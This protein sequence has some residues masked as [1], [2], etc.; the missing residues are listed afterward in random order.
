M[1]L[2]GLSTGDPSA[3]HPGVLPHPRVLQSLGTL[4]TLLPPSV[5]FLGTPI[6]EEQHPHPNPE[7]GGSGREWIWEDGEGLHGD[8]AR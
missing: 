8:R 7:V 1:L 2:S 5:C 4:G 6:P 3:E